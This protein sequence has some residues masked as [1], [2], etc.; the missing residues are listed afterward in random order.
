VNNIDAPMLTRVR[1]EL[2]YRKDVCPVIRG[3]NIE[4]L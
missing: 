3:A 1:Q 4:H 2:E